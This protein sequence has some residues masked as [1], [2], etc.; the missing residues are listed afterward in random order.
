LRVA[1]QRAIPPGDERLMQ[2]PAHRRRAEDV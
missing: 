1:E 2:G